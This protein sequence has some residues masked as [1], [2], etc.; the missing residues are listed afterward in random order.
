MVLG[1]EDPVADLPRGSSRKVGSADRS[2]RKTVV[3]TNSPTVF[4]NS[5]RLRL[6]MGGADEDVVEPRVPVQQHVE[7]GEEPHEEGAAG[8]QAQGAQGVHGPARQREHVDP[9]G[10]GPGGVLP[11]RPGVGSSSS[12]SSPASRSCQ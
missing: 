10:A 3:L 5:S 6:A 9:R 8:L 12:G 7:G 4:S 11:P 1:L 2:E